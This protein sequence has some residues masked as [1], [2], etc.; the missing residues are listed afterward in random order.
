MYQRI[1]KSINGL[2]T[3]KKGKF[4]CTE[5]VWDVINFI[6]T[7]IIKQ[8]FLLESAY[9][10]YLLL[11][12]TKENFKEYQKQSDVQYFISMWLK[13]QSSSSVSPLNLLAMS[14]SSSTLES[15]NCQNNL[16]LTLIKIVSIYFDTNISTWNSNFLYEIILNV[17]D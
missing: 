10:Y 13:E 5:N 16:S 4:N 11:C 15:S 2:C 3:N 14:Q 9:S 1:L 12:S 7:R 17:Y 8:A 6:M